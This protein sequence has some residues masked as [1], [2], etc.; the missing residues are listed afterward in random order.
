MAKQVVSVQ[1]EGE[2]M[3]EMVGKIIEFLQSVGVL[4]NEE[5]KEEAKK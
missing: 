2:T 1:F 3:Q 4:K 5:K